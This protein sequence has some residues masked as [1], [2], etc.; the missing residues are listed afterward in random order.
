MARRS[1]GIAI[2]LAL[3]SMTTGTTALAQDRAGTRAA[4]PLAFGGATYEYTF[5]DDPLTALHGGPIVPII[6]VLDRFPHARLLRPRTQFV[7]EMLKSVE[8]I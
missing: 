8:A 7:V 5:E 3:V 1:T 4:E 2:A 6:K